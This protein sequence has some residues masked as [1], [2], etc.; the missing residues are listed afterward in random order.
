MMKLF[1]FPRS[2]NSREVRLVLAEKGVDYESINVHD[3]AF[4]KN[5]PEFRKASP[6]GKVPAIIDSGTYLSEA[7]DINVYLEE[8][9]PQNPLLPEDPAERQRIREWVRVIDKELVLKIG[10]LLIECII[11]PKEQQKEETKQ[12]YRNDIHKKLKEVD[13]FLGQNEYLFA[14]YSL[15]DIALTPHLVALPRLG[16]EV[17]D[18][19]PRLVR[20]LERV[21]TRPNFSATQ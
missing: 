10:L 12:K 19:Y 8:K 17:A 20:W 16:V 11:K 14:S 6:K 15:A 18:A 21:K 3:K 2:G 13:A 1:C 5:N 4:D 9:F 7:Y